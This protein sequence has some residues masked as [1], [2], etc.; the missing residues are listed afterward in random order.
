MRLPGESG[1]SFA[2]G[3]CN[4]AFCKAFGLESVLPTYCKHVKLNIGPSRDSER[5]PSLRVLCGMGQLQRLL[6][7]VQLRHLHLQNQ[8]LR[9]S[10]TCQKP[11]I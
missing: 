2:E 11:E 1:Q 7:V 10:T 3:H 5:S 9:P 8:V 6:A 4:A